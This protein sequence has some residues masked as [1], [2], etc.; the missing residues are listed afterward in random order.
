MLQVVEVAI[1]QVNCILLVGRT[2]SF[3][4]FVYTEFALPNVRFNLSLS[5]IIKFS[6]T[7]IENLNAI[8]CKR[9]VRRADDDP[10]I[11]RQDT[12]KVSNAG[13]GDYPCRL[14]RSAAPERSCQQLLFNPR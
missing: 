9:I 4:R 3:A 11:G 1:A 12:C 7:R 6:S 14:N 8:I 10:R 5:S 2:S 13:S